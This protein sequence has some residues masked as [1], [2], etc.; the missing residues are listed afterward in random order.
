MNMKLRSQFL[1][2][3]TLHLANRVGKNVIIIE[4]ARDEDLIDTGGRENK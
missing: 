3:P 4:W 2:R 1:W